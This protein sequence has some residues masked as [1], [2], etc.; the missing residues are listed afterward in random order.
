MINILDSNND[1]KIQNRM[2]NNEI[3]Q[4]IAILLRADSPFAETQTSISDIAYSDSEDEIA[5]RLKNIEKILKSEYNVSSLVT[6]RI[7]FVD[8]IYEIDLAIVY[9]DGSVEKGNISA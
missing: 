7:E 8:D 2:T 5:V 1:F 6:E 3:F 9:N 4:A